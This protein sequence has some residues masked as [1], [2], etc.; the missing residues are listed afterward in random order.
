MKL[1]SIT[2]AKFGHCTLCTAA[3]LS[4]PL[5][6]GSLA[7]AASAQEVRPVPSANG[8]T[9]VLTTVTAPAPGAF[10]DMVVGPDVEG[11]I[12][13]RRGNRVEVTTETGEVVNVMLTNETSVQAR[14]G[15]LAIT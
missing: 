2:S 13:D 8:Q 6:L 11:F 10:E 15:F 9:E 5:A 12:S 4:L 14:G 7:G 1:N 3:A